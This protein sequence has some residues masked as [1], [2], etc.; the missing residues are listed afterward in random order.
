MPFLAYMLHCADRT[1]YVGHTDDLD[2][3]LWQHESG[4]FPTC[5]TATRLP[6]KLVWTQDFPTRHEAIEAERRIK[7][8]SRAKK[9]ALIRGD[10]SAIQRLARNPENKER[11]ST[12]SAQTGK[13]EQR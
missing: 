11:A 9:L 4:Y 8:W 5:Y 1:F 3:R 6:V 13:G 7:G 2:V 12:G 10:W